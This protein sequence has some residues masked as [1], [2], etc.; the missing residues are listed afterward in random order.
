[1]IWH[2]NVDW[3]AIILYDYKN[4]LSHA[5]IIQNIALISYAYRNLPIKGT[6][7]DEGTPYSL[8]GASLIITDQNLHSFINGCQII[9]P[10]PASESLELQLCI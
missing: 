4:I 5:K 2:F 10:Q 7:P 6:S 3:F 8:E 1:M 9:Y